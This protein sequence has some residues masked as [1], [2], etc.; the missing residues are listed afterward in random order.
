M[1]NKITIIV[2]SLAVLVTIVSAILLYTT[3]GQNISPIAPESSFAS[4]TISNTESFD[5][6]LNTADWETIK[7]INTSTS[8][9]ATGKLIMVTSPSGGSSLTHTRMI[10]QVMGDFSIE[11]DV[12][13]FMTSSAAE[14][15]SNLY[16][17]DNTGAWSSIYWN[18]SS[19]SIVMNNKTSASAQVITSGNILVGTSTSIKLKL[20]RAGSVIQGFVDKGAG[21]LLVG[22][23]DNAFV[24]NGKIGMG[25]HNS[26]ATG[27]IQASF[28]NFVARFNLASGPVAPAPGQECEITFT[29]LP[30]LPTNTPTPTPTITPTPTP[31]PTGVPG[32]T[33]TP[34]PTVTPTPT[35]P[36]P[37]S[38]GGTCGSNY[39][40]ASGMFCHQGFCRSPQCPTSPNCVCSQ[41]TNT[42]TPTGVFIPGP[43][44]TPRPTPTPTLA[45]L[46]EA[47]T[48][49]TTVAAIIGGIILL[50]VGSFIW[51][52]L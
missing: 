19:N 35:S 48:T 21:Y 20:V 51:M 47:G 14:G 46:K 33:P 8:T 44:S 17:E 7:T 25:T 13:D 3:R 6:T 37:N 1:R 39:N 28:D 5:G 32:V 49:D 41:P 52:G 12:S 43:T 31:T 18:K 38:C 50:G 16:I 10:Q 29:V 2:S 11:V 34:T 26:S 36:P 30:I 45:I 15:V 42:P 23:I 9:V 4:T 24:G 22:S 27:D 40:C